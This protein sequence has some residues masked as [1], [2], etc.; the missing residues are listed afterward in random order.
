MQVKRALVLLD[1]RVK[2]AAC[3]EW[4]NMLNTHNLKKSVIKNG[5]RLPM[6]WNNV[7]TILQIT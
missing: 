6:Q 3:L 2:P 4:Q 7:K 5:H 1:Q